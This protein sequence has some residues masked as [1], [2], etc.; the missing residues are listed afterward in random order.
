MMAPAPQKMSNVQ[1]MKEKVTNVLNQEKFLQFHNNRNPE[2]FPRVQFDVNDLEF[3]D[4]LHEIDHIYKSVHSLNKVFVKYS[5]ASMNMTKI[6]SFFGPQA[7]KAYPQTHINHSASVQINQTHEETSKLY[8][9][10]LANQQQ[11]VI[12]FKMISQKF[13]LLFAKLKNRDKSLE[14]FKHYYDKIQK[15]KEQNQL[16]GRSTDPKEDAKHAEAVQRVTY[17]NVLIQQQNDKKYTEALTQFNALNNSC[18]NDINDIIRNKYKI[19]T[20]IVIRFTQVS[21]VFFSKMSGAFQSVNMLQDKS[22]LYANATAA[23]Q[24]A[25]NQN[26]DPNMNNNNN[27]ND[28]YYEEQKQ[29]DV[30]FNFQDLDLGNGQRNS[31]TSQIQPQVQQ[32]PQIEEEPV[33]DNRYDREYAEMMKEKK[34]RQNSVIGQS[35]VNQNNNYNQN[36]YKEE[37]NYLNQ[38]LQYDQNYYSAP[39]TNNQNNQ[40][41]D[42]YDERY[43]QDVPQQQDNQNNYDNGYDN[44][45]DS[46][47]QNYY[48]QN[49][50]NNNNQ[51]S[52]QQ[53][54]Q[55][56]N[57]DNYY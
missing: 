32:Q 20:P 55:Y 18:Y 10:F 56:G 57:Y 28:Y 53:N 40:V 6:N 2:N 44:N 26:Q 25:S 46:Q 50:A 9:E 41:Y 42:K 38:D 8:K 24:D 19:L 23:N 29:D 3:C 14:K 27:N 35:N 48:D 13:E 1:K 45:Y 16:K 47:N 31:F 34:S 36:S 51:N 12:Q 5:N 22:P 43:Y 11:T 4:L 17:L 15:L 39:Q 33:Y 52:N 30:G 37:S 21:Q 54:D 7:L 49:Y